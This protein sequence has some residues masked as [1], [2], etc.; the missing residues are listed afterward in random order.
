MSVGVGARIDPELLLGERWFASKD[1]GVAAVAV[2]E[3][4]PIGTG[5]LA[6]LRAD[7]ARGR[8]D[9]YSLPLDDERATWLGLASLA[10][11]G[12]SIEGDAGGT[13]VGL[14]PTPP[15]R[16]TPPG[17]L[18]GRQD[19]RPL[20]VDQSNTSVVIGEDGILKLYRRLE[21][22]PN[23]EAELVMALGN[24]PVPD[25]QG[26]I[27]YQPP[28]GR[29]VDVAILQRF[30]A[31]SVDEYERLAEQLDTW[32]RAGCPA[33]VVP[34]L[35][36]DLAD[37]ARAVAALHVALLRLEGRDLR[38]R[39]SRAP[40]I[41]RWSVRAG[42]ALPAAIRAIAPIDPGMAAG[43]RARQAAIAAALAPL[44]AV[45]PGG[46]LIRIHGDL[47]VAQLIRDGSRFLIIDFEGEPTRP[48]AERRRRDTPVRDL[49]S[50]LRS[51]DHITRSAI[52]RS[53]VVDRGPAVDDWL[54]SARRT[55]LDAYGAELATSSH[56][57]EVEPRLLHALEVEKELYE[58]AYAAMY[59]PDWRYAPAAG[60]RWL[61]ERGPDPAG[62]T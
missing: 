52:R 41:D 33:A 42:R 44:G 19:V 1:R 7:M 6:I 35:L 30:V 53:G 47:G 9:L 5:G 37:G 46:T 43:L 57:V 15:T 61:L 25:F 48:G 2:Q 10:A 51:I 26:A 36:A 28:S 21:P 59:L 16:P 17:V 45:A 56:A 55:F 3:R 8:S 60:L 13:L 22:G 23:P 62:R 40:D 50:M 39:S 49:A 54:D 32:L 12:G 58:F 20:G 38:S 27:R 31:G 29:S 4:F 18:S 24:A 14:P 34:P 11:R